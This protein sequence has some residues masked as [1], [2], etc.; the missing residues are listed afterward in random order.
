MDSSAL[1]LNI[2][3]IDVSVENT[4]IE[5]DSIEEDNEAT[6]EE[7]PIAPVAPKPKQKKQESPK[8]GRKGP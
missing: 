1:Q 3:E 5:N 7:T 2:D 6:A 8:F 4:Y